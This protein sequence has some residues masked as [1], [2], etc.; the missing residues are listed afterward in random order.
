[1][2]RKFKRK[3]IAIMSRSDSSG[4]GAGRIA[5]NNHRFLQQSQYGVDH[6]VVYSRDL[7]GKSLKYLTG[8]RVGHFIWRLMAVISRKLG[9]PDIFT[10]ELLILNLSRFRSRYDLIHLHDTSKAISPYTIKELARKVPVVWTLHDCS[11][12]TAGCIYPMDCNNFRTN[13]HNCG[14]LDEWPLNT[15]RDRTARIH[16]LKKAWFLGLDVHLIAPSQW[17]ADQVLASGMFL[18]PPVVIPNG[19]DTDVFSPPAAI[20]ALRKTAGIPDNRLVVILVAHS[21]HNRRK[22]LAYSLQLLESWKD[23][24]HL[25]LIGKLD[26]SLKD[27]LEKY[28]YTSTG[29]LEDQRILANWYS[30]GDVLV[31]T[32][33]ADNLPNVVL[34]SMSCGTP[35]IAFS[36][37]GVPEMIDH[38]VNGWLATPGDFVT[39]EQGLLKAY[40]DGDALRDWAENGREKVKKKFSEELF[41]QKYLDLYAAILGIKDDG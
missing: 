11:P 37:G 21:L 32:S 19:V 33:L 24:I 14:M 18:R 15:R 41:R 20:S 6:W 27:V 36:V 4:G 8:G 22:G 28:S 9:Y 39:L 23:R 29:Y 40:E 7:E 35:V 3:T 30:L 13:C 17:I 26:S 10:P 2:T 25:V 16:V 31:F 5:E 12:F 38:D 34:E 1:M